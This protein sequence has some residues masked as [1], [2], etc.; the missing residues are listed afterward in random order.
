MGVSGEYTIF[1]RLF[2]LFLSNDI[3][4][5]D[6]LLARDSFEKVS[7][8]PAQILGGINEVQTLHEFRIS[9]VSTVLRFVIYNSPRFNVKGFYSFLVL[10]A[11]PASYIFYS[12]WDVFL[13]LVL[14]VLL[15]FSIE[16]N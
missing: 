6:K 10:Q 14:L 3:A 15:L 11:L 4:D 2:F 1:V 12:F 5:A 13:L 16:I 8:T 9:F 7:S